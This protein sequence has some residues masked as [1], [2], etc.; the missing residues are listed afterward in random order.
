MA[1]TALLAAEGDEY[2]PGTFFV[3]VIDTHRRASSVVKIIT[4]RG[5]CRSPA[6]YLHAVAA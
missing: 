5:R 2:D 3:A 6:V 1:R 4:A